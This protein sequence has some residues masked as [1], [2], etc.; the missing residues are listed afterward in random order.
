M[1]GPTPAITAHARE[2]VAAMM[3]VWSA[4]LC[5]SVAAESVH[6]AMDEVRSTE[7]GRRRDVSLKVEVESGRDG[8][9]VIL[10]PRDIRRRVGTK[11]SRVNVARWIGLEHQICSKSTVVLDLQMS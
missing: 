2:P 9:F 4:R 10:S 6:G 3:G 1:P 8:V 11:S 7:R 5:E